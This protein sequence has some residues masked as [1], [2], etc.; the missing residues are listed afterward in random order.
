MYIWGEN[1]VFMRCKIFYILLLFATVLLYD[2]LKEKHI[3]EENTVFAEIKEDHENVE[4][5]LAIL[6]T[7]SV[8]DLSLQQNNP[9]GGSQ[10]FKRTSSFRTLTGKEALAFLKN[11]PLFS[12]E[13]L[14]VFQAHFRDYYARQKM[15]GYYLYTLCKLRI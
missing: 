6:T 9:A 13:A 12:F 7:N 3:T 8:A 2:T 4:H 1:S 14:Q 10:S 11:S 15:E 5:L